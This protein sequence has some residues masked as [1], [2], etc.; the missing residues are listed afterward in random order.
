MKCSHEIVI[1]PQICYITIPFFR[2]LI[3]SFSM[4]T[5]R[6]VL[7]PT[8]IFILIAMFIYV[9]YL[10]K[11]VK[12]IDHIFLI[13]IDTLRA[14]HLGAYGYQRNTSPF[15][16]SIAEKGVL[17]ENAFSQSSTTC[18]SHASIF[19]GLYPSQHRVLANHYLL[20]E[21]NRTL[22]EILKE[23]GFDTTAFTSTDVHFLS[24]RLDQGFEFYEEPM[25]AQKTYGI[26]Y[27]PA[28]LTVNNAMIW[29]DNF[30][31]ARKLFM[32]I[33]LYDP[34]LP[35]NPPPAY[36][37]NL[38]RDKE[39]FF[40][41]IEKYGINL[42]VF[43]NNPEKL[44]QYITQY[45]AEIKYVDE[46]LQRFYG[47]VE[48]KG[49]NKNSLWIITADH[50]EGLGQHNF[51]NHA[52]MVYQEQ[53]HVPLIFLFTDLEIESK[54]L[55][56][57]VENFDIFST[58]LDILKI[59]TEDELMREVQSDSQWP[60]IRGLKEINTERF[61]FAERNI[62]PEKDPF[63]P[64]VPEHRRRWEK[65]DKYSIQDE[66]YKYIFRTHY[67]DEFYDLKEDPYEKTNL[68]NKSREVEKMLKGMISKYIRFFDKYRQQKD[69]TVD[70]KVLKKLRSL[71]YV[72]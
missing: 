64:K 44:Y 63:P 26:R 27:R 49:L 20:S 61:A 47:Y 58:V 65:G 42:E 69:Q 38:D 35:Y 2:A 29:L 37:K 62:Y 36:V 4:K 39:N 19:T 51:L 40:N 7:I 66:N 25:D 28:R 18:P 9:I 59:K 21:S 5:K 71:G 56:H 13:T 53:I 23:N 34:H 54:R 3:E 33:H 67:P 16:D 32:W 8:A 52:K 17:F 24:T 48:N 6:I 45:D 41:F 30:N 68:I 46:E 57:I 15:I 1:A 12:K 31:P 11:K 72:N 43:D 60:S 55:D 50:G 70:P 10:S 22:A 14:D